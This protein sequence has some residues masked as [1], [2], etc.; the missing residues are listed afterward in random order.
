MGILLLAIWLILVGINWAGWVAISAV[1]LGILAIITGIILL[2][3]NRSVVT[4][5]IQR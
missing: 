5:N 2:V 4:T 3:E 1:I